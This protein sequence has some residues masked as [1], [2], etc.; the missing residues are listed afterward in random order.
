MKC[1]R[2]LDMIIFVKNQLISPSAYLKIRNKQIEQVNIKNT[3][4]KPTHRSFLPPP[5]KKSKT[6]QPGSHVSSGN[7]AHLSSQWSILSFNSLMAGLTLWPCLF[8]S[9]QIVFK[10][11]HFAEHLA[12]LIALVSARAGQRLLSQAYISV[13]SL[14]A[15]V[16]LCPTHVLFYTCT[17]NV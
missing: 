2:V 9:A 15:C 17:S 5:S 4:V 11:L 10:W 14:C 8:S 16:R 3:Y 13:N 7:R 12:P 1:W 6:K